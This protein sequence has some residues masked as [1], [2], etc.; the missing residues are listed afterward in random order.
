MLKHATAAILAT[1]GYAGRWLLATNSVFGM[2]SGLSCPEKGQNTITG[3]L[4][5]VLKLNFL[6]AAKS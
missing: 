4:K 2:D 1:F 6:Y 3:G 5:E